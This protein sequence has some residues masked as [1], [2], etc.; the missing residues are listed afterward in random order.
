VSFYGLTTKDA[1]GPLGS[2][3]S[4]RLGRLIYSGTPNPAVHLPDFDSNAPC[5]M[6]AG[7]GGYA[8]QWH[9]SDAAA[10]GWNNTTKQLSNTIPVI[11]ISFGGNIG[12]PSGEYGITIRNSDGEVIISSQRRNLEIVAHGTITVTSARQI[13]EITYP[14][15]DEPLLWVQMP[16]SVW[17]YCGAPQDDNVR[18]SAETATSF[19]YFVTGQRKNAIGLPSGYHA[20]IYDPAGRVVFSSARAYARIIGAYGIAPNEFVSAVAGPDGAKI[21][22]QWQYNPAP[23]DS[24][25]CLN[26]RMRDN[27]TTSSDYVWPIRK[28][29]VNGYDYFQHQRFFDTIQWAQYDLRLGYN[30]DTNTNIFRRFH[31]IAADP[32]L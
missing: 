31:M 5:V 22:F 23:S 15:V 6:L 7:F 10:I 1:L 18:V 12:V 21:L 26:A 8:R 24:F 28:L 3:S 25:V 11:I 29:H 27:R 9:V 16:N 19:K 17:I 2:G 32:G 20:T 30:G 4:D 13:H 14:S